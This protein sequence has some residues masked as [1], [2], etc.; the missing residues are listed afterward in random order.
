MAMLTL[1]QRTQLLVNSKLFNLQVS[2]L[3][4]KLSL[5]P[6]RWQPESTACPATTFG[7]DA[8]GFG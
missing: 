6:Q 3:L 8:S 7:D 5:V 1:V 2:S 4:V